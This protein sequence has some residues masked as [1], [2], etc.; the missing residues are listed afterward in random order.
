M[1][2]NRAR[3]ATAGHARESL[4]SK[5][6]FS[7]VVLYLFAYKYFRYFPEGQVRIWMENSRVILA[8]V[9]SSVPLYNRYTLKRFSGFSCG[10][11]FTFKIINIHLPTELRGVARSIEKTY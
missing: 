10:L 3:H 2:T 11:C 8:H 9:W 7:P 4:K 1:Y 6:Q 5:K